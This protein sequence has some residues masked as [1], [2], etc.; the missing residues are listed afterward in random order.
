MSAL[1]FNLHA[2]SVLAPGMRSLAEFRLVCRSLQPPVLP[3]GLLLPSPQMLPANERR[4]ASQVVKLTQACIEQVLQSCPFPGDSLRSVF[5][6][7][8]GT[9]EIC[10][11]ILEALATTRQ[12]SPLTFSNS[13]QNAPSGYFSIA[14]RNRQSSTVVSLGLESFASGLLCAVTETLATECPVLI[15]AYDPAM[16]APMDEQLPI[17]EAIATA[18]VISGLNMGR[19]APLLGSFALELEPA[20]VHSPSTWPR[21]LPTSWSASSSASALAALGLLEA[22]TST[23]YRTPFGAQLLSLRRMDGERS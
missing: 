5:V 3:S 10:Q 8:E 6:T 4:R 11:Q 22:P 7:D 14:W 1:H 18:W 15:V 2:A 20:G 23:A 19:S 12:V 17:R 21:W 9:G 16:S 13:V